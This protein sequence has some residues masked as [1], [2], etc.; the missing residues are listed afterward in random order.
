MKRN[1]YAVVGSCA[2]LVCLCLPY[3][4][5]PDADRQWLLLPH[6][7]P[8]SVFAGFLPQ[9]NNGGKLFFFNKTK[10][11]LSGFSAVFQQK[12][13]HPEKGTVLYTVQV[14]YARNETDAKALYGNYLTVEER[15]KNFVK[16]AEPKQ[17]SVDD[18]VLIQSDRLIYLAVRRGLVLYFVQIDNGYIDLAT[19]KNIMLRKIDFIE[20]HADLFKT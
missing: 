16:K 1:L 19:V 17:Y 14:S 18:V 11:S 6:D 12:L 3:G 10:T 13:S 5:L 15:L 7:F 8:D 20:R 9:K 2:A 4:A